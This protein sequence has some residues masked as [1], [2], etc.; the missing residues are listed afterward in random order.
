MTF[1]L[2]ADKNS[3]VSSYFIVEKGFL[4]GYIRKAR[5]RPDALRPHVATRLP[6]TCISLQYRDQRERVYCHKTVWTPFD[7]NEGPFQWRF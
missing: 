3:I 6:V 2:S 1:Y 4:W 5:S 7:T